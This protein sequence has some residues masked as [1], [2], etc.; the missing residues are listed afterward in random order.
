M[1]D[2]G[3]WVGLETLWQDVRFGWRSLKRQPLL[4]VAV[5]ATLAFGIG[6]MTAIFSV[7][8]TVLLRPL[9]YP[10]PDRMVQFLVTGPWGWAPAATIPKFKIWREQSDIFQDVAAYDSF[11]GVPVLSL[12]V[13]KNGG[14][15][16]GDG[17]P[18]PIKAMRVTAG[19]F[20]LFGA[21]VAPGRTFTEEE[22]SP[23]GPQVVVLSSGVWRRRFSADPAIV[24]KVIR[25][26][27][28]PY[29]VVGIMRPEFESDPS[30]GVWV[31][32]QFN[33]NSPE[34]TKL[35][36]TVAGRL[37]PGITLSLARTRL[38]LAAERF[39]REFPDQAAAEPKGGFSAALLQEAMVG[40]VRSSLYIFS[41]AVG[42]VLLIA[43]A[44]VASLLLARAMGRQRELAIRAAVGAGRG[45][46]VR[47]LLTES[48]V[49]SL[50]GGAL[51][52]V[53]GAIAIRLLL[54]LNPGNLPRIGEFA[55]AVTPD[56]RV[57]AFTAGVS[58]G[59]SILIGLGPALEG[60]LA[61]LNARLRGGSGIVGN[62]TVVRKHKTLS[63][64]VIGEVSIAVVLLIGAGLLV[65]TFVTMRSVNPGFDSKNVLAV[66]TSLSESRIRNVTTMTQLVRGVVE[67]MRVLP[68]VV[69]AG[70]AW[71]VPLD[72]TC[73]AGGRF[74]VAGQEP[75]GSAFS[76][77][78]AFSS[79]WS[80]VS[81]AYFEVFR[82]PLLRGRFFAIQ[83]DSASQPVVIVNEALARQFLATGDPLNN[84]L[85]LGTGP[86]QEPAR[87]IVGVVQDTHDLDLRTSVRP[88]VY[89]PLSQVTDAAIAVRRENV[90][91][92]WI[93]RTQD[94]PVMLSTAIQDAISQ[95]SGDLPITSVRTMRE[96]V[97]GSSASE[98]FATLVLAIFGCSA[99]AL[100]AI[101]VYG[102]T[103]YS[104]Q[105]RTR[106]FGI[107]MALGAPAGNLQRSI[108]FEGLRLVAIGV[109]LGSIAALGL[110]RLIVH[111]LYR[112][113]PWDPL[114]FLSAPVVLGAVALMAI[115]I[116]A[117]HVTQ[118]D[119]LT[120][121]RYE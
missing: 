119:P 3:K 1:N 106:E 72:F 42:F 36:F 91:L 82:I 33:P 96:V 100:A 97:A 54:N 120:A 57:L 121:L 43:C 61:D 25:L 63:L 26:N 108:I 30:P 81:P 28:Q 49:L 5:V 85:I 8:N 60:S 80:S 110:T 103:A 115:W 64:L 102:L 21:T 105:N 93:A 46:L 59:T 23:N 15:K 66:T 6:G 7:V 94:D 47:Q 44:N 53:F 109:L 107:R 70:A 101:G 9:S 56:W 74:S 22:C 90:P 75:P 118:V 41:G 98:A 27:G 99:L 71:C 65:R 48:L 29:T 4:T 92:A 34:H 116:P 62:G 17:K 117:R 20:R 113:Q 16:N 37:K 114:V 89:V 78:N 73:S 111:L 77:G 31:P 10:E 112:V 40:D 35:Y 84:R 88:T 45:R 19:Y 87:Q 104:V 95:A 68:G 2:A 86:N 79:G 13:D 38:S 58:L 14:D 55:S 39:F 12:G 18:E 50:L 76:T 83:D 69:A 24:G 51:G 67:R 11:F 32:F 52:L